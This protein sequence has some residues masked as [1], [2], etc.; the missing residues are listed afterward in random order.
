MKKLLFIPLLFACYIGMGQAIDSSLTLIIGKPI[1]LGK[2]LI[3]QND[4]PNQM[5]WDAA[6]EACASLGKGWR[7]PTKEELNLLYQNK[8]KISG[9]GNVYYW[10]SEA[11][12]NGAWSQSFISG[13]QSNASNTRPYYVRAV[14]FF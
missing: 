8:K 14:R 2:I 13:Y 7:L 11:A 3:A 1:Q 9:F 5:G 10:S 4:F 12:S 6:K